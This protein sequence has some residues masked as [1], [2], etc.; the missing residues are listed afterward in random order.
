[1]SD[2]NAIRRMAKDIKERAEAEA[3]ASAARTV[4]NIQYQLHQDIADAIDLRVQRIEERSYGHDNPYLAVFDFGGRLYF[5]TPSSKGGYHAHWNENA[6]YQF[7]FDTREEF[8][9]RLVAK[10]EEITEDGRKV[11]EKGNYVKG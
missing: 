4:K 7:Q 1:M 11:D 5:V 6:S 9:L 10:D 8:L 3:R 2:D